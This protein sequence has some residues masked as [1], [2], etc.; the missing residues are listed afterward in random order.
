MPINVLLAD[1]RPATREAVRQILA[2]EAGLCVVGEAASG[3]EALQLAKLL[4]PDVVVMDVVMPG[5]GGVEATRRISGSVPEASVIGLS[6]HNDA[7]VREAMRGAG[8]IAFVA[9]EEAFEELPGAIRRAAG[10]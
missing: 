7:G 5:I 8:A 4:R 3:E 1:D 9:K 2:A 10:G 6:L